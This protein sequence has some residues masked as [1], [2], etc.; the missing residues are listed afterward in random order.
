[1]PLAAERRCNLG[2]C[3]VNCVLA[4]WGGWSKCSS[5]CG[6]GMA[7]RVRD[8]K[9][10]MQ[11][12]GKQCGSTGESKQC[13]VAACEKDCVLLPWTRW[14]DCSKHCDGGSKKR[15][16]MIL[17]P[18]EGSGS[19]ADKW[20]PTRLQYEPCALHRCKVPDPKQAMKCNQ[21]MDVIMVMD[22]TPRGGKDTFAA[23]IKGAKKFVDAFKGEGITAKPQFALFHYTGPRTWSGVSKC[24]GMSTKK[25]DMEKVCK[26]T[27]VQHFTEDMKKTKSKLDGLTFQPGSKLL[28]L[29]LMSVQSE[30]ALGNK[31][32]RTIVVVWVDGNPLSFRKTLL[33]S[34]A[35]RKK[36]RLVWVAVTK[37]SP[38]AS[39]KKWASR[40][41]QENLITVKKGKQFKRGET[42]THIIANICPRKFPK[43][44]T[45]PI[46]DGGEL[47]PLDLIQ[48]H[49]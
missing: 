49:Q 32:F 42:G 37:Y 41:W 29:A 25:V 30:F 22:G 17:S 4:E 12:G 15:E 36:A 26:I 47:P 48:K 10:P 40:R 46:K 39:L 16:R 27:L 9:T 45:E 33:A 28:S 31:N 18:A 2:P 24:T 3:P 35:V 6:G 1:L 13:N 7:S 38:L 20:D 19:C 5:K 8:V 21:S 34:R 23:E 44:K 43:L 14:T 11:Y